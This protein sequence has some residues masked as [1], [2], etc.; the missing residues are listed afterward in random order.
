M[1]SPVEVG[2]PNTYYRDTLQWLS[3]HPEAT[4]DSIARQIVEHDSDFRVYTCVR[5]SGLRHLP[6]RINELLQPF[7]N[8]GQH[9]RSPEISQVVYFGGREKVVDLRAYIEALAEVNA[10][11]GSE[12]STFC[13]W[14]NSNLVASV[15]FKP[16]DQL[17][18]D[19]CCGLSVFLPTSSADIDRYKYLDLYRESRLPGFWKDL[20]RNTSS[21]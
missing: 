14:M 16:H 5:D 12:V 20:L 7:R 11:G 21:D 10:V 15:H 2:V 3:S 18:P 1:C 6:Q 8:R 9:L 19:N 13:K 17:T 4:G